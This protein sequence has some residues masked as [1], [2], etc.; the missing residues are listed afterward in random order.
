MGAAIKAKDPETTNSLC[1]LPQKSISINETNKVVGLHTELNPAPLY[2]TQLDYESNKA[3][4]KL[5]ENTHTGKTKGDQ[6]LIRD[7][8]INSYDTS[9][10]PLTTAPNHARFAREQ[11]KRVPKAQT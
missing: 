9:G 1:S 10:T 3:F 11:T 7:I 8:M 5:E 4:S 6:S 2:N